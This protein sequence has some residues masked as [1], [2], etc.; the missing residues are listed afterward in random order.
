[1][2]SNTNKLTFWMIW[3]VGVVPM[4]VAFLM[5]YTGMLSPS[6]TVNHGVLIKSQSIAQWQ[7]QYQDKAWQQSSQWQIL[8]TQPVQC[9]SEECANW[10][11]SLPKVIK[12]LGKDSDRVV[13]QQV[14]KQKTMLQTNK[15]SELGEAV[16][17]VDPH[18]N[19]VMRYAPELTPRQLL[20]DLKK[21]L[22]V[23]G[24]G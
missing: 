12:L 22:K 17:I 6:N 7:L 20:K 2:S 14:G 5:Y 18:G 11:S 15:L 19:L 3:M 10:S 1:M 13:L 9:Q 21:L 8:H 16:W 4:A 23:S 24:I